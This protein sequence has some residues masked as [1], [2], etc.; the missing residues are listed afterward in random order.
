MTNILVT[1]Y[2]VLHF[3]KLVVHVMCPFAC[4]YV[5]QCCAKRF[6]PILVIDIFYCRLVLD[7]VS[8]KPKCTCPFFSAKHTDGKCYQVQKNKSSSFCSTNIE[9]LTQGMTPMAVISQ[10]PIFCLIFLVIDPK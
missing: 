9:G 8:R 1:Y 6:I 10:S 3:T 7:E 5:F 4:T 2:V